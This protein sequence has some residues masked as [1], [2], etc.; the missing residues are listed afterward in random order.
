MTMRD[1]FYHVR[2]STG[3]GSTA[4]GEGLVILK[5]E[6]VQ[7]GDF[8]MLY[9]G[10]MSAQGVE[11]DSGQVGGAL[12]IKRYQPGPSSVFGPLNEFQLALRGRFGPG[13]FRLSGT[14]RRLLV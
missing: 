13:N 11:G 1:G 3:N 7:G 6:T 10:T 12:Q 14:R 8:G 9:Q 5:G 4:T 2:F